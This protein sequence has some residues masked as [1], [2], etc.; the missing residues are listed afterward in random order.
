MNLEELN[1]ELDRAAKKAPELAPTLEYYRELVKELYE[2]EA[3]L[4]RVKLTV[5]EPEVE[6]NVKGGAPLSVLEQVP[7][8]PGA[9]GRAF[10]RVT[11]VVWRH[12]GGRSEELATLARLT[13]NYNQILE[14][15][16]SEDLSALVRLAEE[17]GVDPK[18]FAYLVMTTL[19]PFFRRYA[20]GLGKHLK[21][22]WWRDTRCPVCG[23]EGTFGVLVGDG[24]R[25]LHCPLC[26]WEWQV[27]RLQCV[28]CG[29]EDHNLL[30][31]LDVEEIPGYAIQACQKCKGY[32]KVA[33]RRGAGEG[34]IDLFLADLLTQGL[35]QVAAD[36][37]YTRDP[38]VAQ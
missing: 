20:Q 31:E 18:L 19:R 7:V 35:D 24:E 13:W 36:R 1:A 5:S 38:E 21:R 3:E 23:Q 25:L 10:E 8:D 34:D 9:F 28:H 33:D 2:I 29:N 17:R 32:L 15:Y 37:G 4:P 11:N 16:F 30:T 14:V 6:I 22:E 12:Q 26:D 27:R